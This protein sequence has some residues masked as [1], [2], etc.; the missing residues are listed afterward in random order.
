MTVHSEDAANQHDLELFHFAFRFLIEEPDRILAERGLNRS[1]HRILFFVAHGGP[2]M[3]LTD[4]LDKLKVSRQALHRPMRQLL[5]Q[6]LVALSPVPSNRRMLNV[7]LNPEG[8]TLEA[9]LSALQTAYLDSAFRAAGE[10]A[11]DAWRRVMAVL[12]AEPPKI[13]DAD[14]FSM[15]NGGRPLIGNM[16]RR[17]VP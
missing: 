7:T 13:E 6:N 16:P 15:R 9:R 10:G 3:T 8:A 17:A 1:H 2:D 12:A 4:L 14:S 11:A 5:D